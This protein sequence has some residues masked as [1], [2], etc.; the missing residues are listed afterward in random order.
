MAVGADANFLIR[1]WLCNGARK[2]RLDFCFDICFILEQTAGPVGD[3]I[4]VP[5]PLHEKD[6]HTSQEQASERVVCLGGTYCLRAQE[7]VL[8]NPAGHTAFLVY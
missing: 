1:V 4:L 8:I 2:G 3:W 5:R 7:K 6:T